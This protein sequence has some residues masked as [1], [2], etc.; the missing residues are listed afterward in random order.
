MVDEVG[1][2]FAEN[3]TPLRIKLKQVGDYFEGT[4]DTSLFGTEESSPI[5]S[6]ANGGTCQQNFAV[7]MSDGYW[8]GGTSP[9]V[10]N[11]DSG[12]TSDGDANNT[13]Y[14]GGTYADQNTGQ[15]NTLADVAMHYYERDLDTGLANKVPKS[16]D[17][18]EQQHLV[19]Y[20]VAF[21][22][23][24]TLTSNPSAADT[25]FNWPDVSSG[26]STTIDDMRHAAWNG[27]GE[28]LSAAS[29]SDLIQSFNNA[30]ASIASR[31]SS[32]SSVATNSTRLQTNSKI[33]Q[34]RFTTAA[35]SGDILAY[36]I[37][38]T[39][40]DVAT[41][42]WQAADRLPS[43]PN[44]HIYTSTGL[45]DSGVTFDWASA[46]GALSAA[47]LDEGQTNYL[48]GDQSNE[49]SLYRSRSSVF[50]DVINSDPIY[51][52][53]ENFDYYLLET[54][55][56]GVATYDDYLI[57]SAAT[58]KGTRTGMLY[59]GANDGML[60]ALLGE[61]VVSSPCDPD[62]QNCE[63][64][65]IF[66]Y[67]P[68]AVHSNLP[69]LTSTNYSHKYFV[70]N[71]AAQGDAYI[72]FD[73][74]P[75][76]SIGRWGTALVG[77][78][79][80]GGKGLFALDISNPLNFSAS[81]VLWDIDST[82]TNFAD[83]GY[84]FAKASIVKLNDDNSTSNNNWGVIVGNGYESTSGKA[85]LYII[86]LRTGE[87]IWKQEVDTSGGNGLSTPIA[88]DTDNDD[89]ADTVY[90][91]DLKGNMW[92][93]DI[94]DPDV[95]NWEIAKNDGNG[96][97]APKVPL[98]TACTADP[99]TGTNSQPIT[100]K[101]QVV[102][103]DNGDII[104]L[105]GTGKYFET[106]D[107][108]DVAQ[109]QT[110][111]SILDDASSSNQV[112]GRDDLLEQTITHELTAA[113]T[114]LDF[115]TRVTTNND[116]DFNSDQGWYLDLYFDGNTD[117][118]NDNPGERVV[119]D[120]LVR[121]GR[122]IFPTLIPDVSPCAFGGTSYLMEID[123]Q[124]GSRLDVSPFDLNG[125]G[126]IDEND[127]VEIEVTDEHGNTITIKVPVSGKESTVGIIKTP[128]VISTGDN[129]LKYTS[130]STGDIE[131]T[132]ES[133]GD[134]LGRQSWIQVR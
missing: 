10:G 117:N 52:E 133:S 5:L 40:G 124:S 83:L 111:Y 96:T 23:N 103:A 4:T 109:T 127:W 19:T 77:T 120:P 8:N 115:N 26:T 25:S 18:N 86:G 130:G 87:I 113:Q 76:D 34:A 64:E 47:G 61:G 31:T 3:G 39:S 53:Q 27:R 128:G 46:S 97:N 88:I 125:D 45:A 49:G 132:T 73:G 55:T 119:A 98:F 100:S 89:I 35:W 108:T 38:S 16:S 101:P 79:G 41:L 116:I 43:E 82:D 54:L 44:R 102:G 72:N 129:E 94:S 75:S 13:D 68:K 80:A 104:V 126:V 123:A 2:I 57:G 90:A 134:K 112:S 9:G 51:S 17:G 11:A 1:K 37:N 59:V 81:D 24:G 22:V 56:G 62:S 32:A 42:A 66:A 84:T 20:T 30:V 48:R 15:S 28:F 107:N 6:A 33:Y 14:D 74:V 93:F 65:E 71:T 67:I 118:V 106:G 122:V 63:G 78:L 70:D 91:G 114:G 95:S 29:P 85:V 110:F 131:V 21:G 99:C 105:F 60:H 36:N 69:S 58:D 121:N 12:D 7:V 92:A 50:G